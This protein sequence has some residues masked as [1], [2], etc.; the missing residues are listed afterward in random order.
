MRTFLASQQIYNGRLKKVWSRMGRTIYEVFA[1][2][3]MKIY[4][5]VCGAWFTQ[6]KSSRAAMHS[7][8]LHIMS[9]LRLAYGSKSASIRLPLSPADST[10]SLAVVSPIFMKSSRSFELG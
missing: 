3:E 2:G 7:Q 9:N 1:C 10:Q 5:S 8:C 6:P 4:S